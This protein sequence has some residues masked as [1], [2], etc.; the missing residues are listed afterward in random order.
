MRKKI[1]V[2]AAFFLFGSTA[3][4]SQSDSTRYINGLPVSEDDTA[5]Q[6]PQT[7]FTPANKR[8]PVAEAYLPA[9]LREVLD[10]EEIYR[11]WQDTTIY[12]ERNTGLYIVPIRYSE[13]VKIFGLTK[14]GEPVTFSEVA[15]PGDQ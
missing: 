11:G 3:V 9:E 12:F 15:S 2:I 4:F 8:V 10:E 5:R 1:L 14:D 13:G 7:D 6:A